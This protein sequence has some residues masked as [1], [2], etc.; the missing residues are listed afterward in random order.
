MEWVRAVRFRLAATSAGHVSCSFL[1]AAL[2]RRQKR[3]AGPL[4]ECGA[5]PTGRSK[6]EADRTPSTAE[7]VP[8]P[9]TPQA[10][11]GGKKNMRRWESAGAYPP[12]QPVRLRRAAPAD[13]KR[14][15]HGRLKPPRRSRT[16]PKTT[17]ARDLA[18]HRKNTAIRLTGSLRPART[19]AGEGIPAEIFLISIRG[20]PPS[21]G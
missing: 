15:P 7:A 9:R 4:R 19:T 6:N 16:L 21:G 13:G 2:K 20:H 1:S 18:A 5:L 11:G 8:L 12:R 14:G 3:N 17:G 10:A